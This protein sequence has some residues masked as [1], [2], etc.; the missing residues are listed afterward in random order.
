MSGKIA[1]GIFAVL[2]GLSIF[3]SLPPV[4]PLT[5]MFMLPAIVLITKG[6]TE[7]DKEMLSFGIGIGLVIQSAYYFYSQNQISQI[8]DNVSSVMLLC[9][10]EL[11][12]SSDFCRKLENRLYKKTD[13][14][15]DF[16]YD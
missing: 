16:S 6:E 8:R 13:L 2:V 15:L 1:L 3:F 9:E 10:S 12:A 5:A 11:S 14:R 7:M 4:Y